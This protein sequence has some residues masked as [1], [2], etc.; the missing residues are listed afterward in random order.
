MVNTVAKAEIVSIDEVMKILDETSQVIEH[1]HQLEQKSQELES[2]TAELRDA[3]TRLQQLDRLKDDFLSTISHELRT[4]LTS[5][6]SFT[7]ILFDNPE[8][9]RS[10]R[11]R[12]LGI[13]VKESERL[14]RLINQVLDLAKM[15]AGRMEWQIDR[16]NPKAAVEEAI[17]ATSGLFE[18]RG[19]RLDVHLPLRLPMVYADRDRLIQVMVNLLSNAANYCDEIEGRVVVWGAGG[20]DQI[21]IGVGDNGPGIPKAAQAEIFEKF[22]QAEALRKGRTT[23]TGLGLSICR[24]IVEHFGGAIRVDSR[25][26]EGARFV[27]SVPT[28]AAL[29]RAEEGGGRRSAIGRLIPA[30]GRRLGLGRKKEVPAE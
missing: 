2:A 18:D 25:P 19:I 16:V 15:E 8:L 27:F 14:T 11:E 13:I 21:E 23:G 9:E 10:E 12:F 22:Q 24:Q 26:G 17:A 29:R 20:A 4:P 3:N 1:S 30:A 5:I 28:A 6:R 7:E